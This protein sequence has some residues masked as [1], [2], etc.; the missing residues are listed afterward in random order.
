M[1]VSIRLEGERLL[2]R[3]QLDTLHWSGRHKI[4]KRIKRDVWVHITN[5]RLKKSLYPLQTAALSITSYRKRLLDPDN[6]M[7]GCKP[8]IDALKTAGIIVDDRPENVELT[9]K[10]V[11]SKAFAVEITVEPIV[12]SE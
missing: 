11:K 5:A 12:Q 10:Q 1:S 9:V 6:L 2:S 4:A 8:Y 7:G 3:N